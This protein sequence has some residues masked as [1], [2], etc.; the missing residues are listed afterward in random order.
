MNRREELA[1]NLATV[2]ERIPN[3][4]VLLIVVT[5]TYPVSDVQILRELG[6]TDFGENRSEEGL[7]KSQ[8][9]PARWHFQGQIQSRK[10]KDIV[11]WAD[12][13]HSLDDLGHAQ[14]MNLLATKPI[15]I[16]LQLSLDGDPNRGGVT[17]PHLA[18]LGQAIMEMENLR[19]VGL[20][21]VPP[22]AADPHQ[23]F[24]AVQ[25]IHQEFVAKFPEA[26]SLSAGMS[27]DFEIALQYGATHIRVGSSILGPRTYR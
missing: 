24:A 18:Q 22:V 10:I 2:R 26:R 27:G 14:K 6:V 15:D 3:R 5:K 7:A 1:E 13:V 4:D 25:Q 11:Q 16:F 8:S 21:C 12:V 19:L 20:M 23:S 9:V 17:A